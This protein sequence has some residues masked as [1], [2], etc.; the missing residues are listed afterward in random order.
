MA[1]KTLRELGMERMEPRRG[2]V[3][4]LGRTEKKG[5][6]EPMALTLVVFRS[7]PNGT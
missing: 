1:A 6:G 2:R 5:G 7:T 3:P 4:V